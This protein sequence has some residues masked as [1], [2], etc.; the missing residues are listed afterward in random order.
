MFASNIT[1]N[2][3][4]AAAKTFKQV[5]VDST[6]S[7]RIDD[8]TTNLEPRKMVVRHTTSTPKGTSVTVDRHLLQFSVVQMDTEN[9]PQT[10]TVNLTIAVPRSPAISD[11]DVDHLL[12]FV[13][14]W[15][16]VAANVDGLLLG[17]S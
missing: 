7:I 14:N 5:Q 9:E 10:A 17:E 16:G 12:A 15:I 2:D 13:K 1:I 3:S 4:A 11:A 6:G 8:S